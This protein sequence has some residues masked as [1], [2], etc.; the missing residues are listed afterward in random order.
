MQLSLLWKICREKNRNWNEKNSLIVSAAADRKKKSNTGDGL[1][2]F[3]LRF[4]FRV[5]DVIYSTCSATTRWRGRTVDGWPGPSSLP[6][7]ETSS[8]S[9]CWAASKALTRRNCVTKRCYHVFSINARLR[10]AAW[11]KRS[12]WRETSWRIA[13]WR[14]RD[15]PMLWITTRVSDLVVRL[16]TLWRVFTKTL[17]IV[18]PSND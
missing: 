17:S 7:C 9:T 10:W 6:R 5:C 1:L 11:S 4:F 15:F 8:R 2:W 12:A 18:R 3:G 13:S 14:W 16:L